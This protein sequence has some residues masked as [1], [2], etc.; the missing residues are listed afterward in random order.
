LTDDDDNDDTVK[1]LS[2]APIREH[3]I[4][5]MNSLG[6]DRLRFKSE[7]CHVCSAVILGHVLEL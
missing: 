3:Q 2:E 6:S 1:T 4:C 5:E 7:L